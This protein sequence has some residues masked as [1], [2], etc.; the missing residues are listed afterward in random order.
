MWSSRRSGSSARSCW[1]VTPPSRQLPDLRFQADVQN[2]WDCGGQ[3]AF[4]DNYLSAQ[5]DTI[6]SNVA[7]LIYVFDMTTTEWEKDLHYFEDNL[8]ALRENSPDAGVWVL[9]NK[10]DLVD[11]EDPKRAKYAE[12]RAEVLALNERLSKDVENAGGCRCFP[13]SIWDESLY[14]VSFRSRTGS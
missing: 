13:T 4:L 3:D 6:F 14:K 7:V 10:M 9:M 8:A 12:R 2:L 1:C 11:S 5:R